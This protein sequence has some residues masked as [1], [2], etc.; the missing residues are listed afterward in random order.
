MVSKLSQVK[1]IILEILSDGME[2]TSDEMRSRINKE[3]IELDKKC[4][5]LRTAIYQLRN[6]GTEIYS[7]FSVS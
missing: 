1:N 5:T 2:H 3:G 6:N 7:M 4:S